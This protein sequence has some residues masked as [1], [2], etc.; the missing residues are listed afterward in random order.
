MDNNFNVD[1]NAFKIGFK[2]YSI[3]KPEEISE[4]KADYYGTADYE[5]AVIRIA[6]KFEQ[7]DRNHTFIH[8]MLHC[9]CMRFGLDELHEDEHTLDL[10]ALGIYE[11]ILDNPQI[12]K[13]A[14]I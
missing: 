13:M 9:I 2:T 5:K 1:L 14:N 7:N 12:F 6:G 3:E 4:I 8:E 11:A 10:L